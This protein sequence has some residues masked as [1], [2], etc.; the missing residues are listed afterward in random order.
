MHLNSFL[1]IRV[2]P[3]VLLKL[4]KKVLSGTKSL[5]AAS[6]LGNTGRE[7]LIRLQEFVPGTENS[8]DHSSKSGFIRPEF[9]MEDLNNLSSEDR[10]PF[11]TL[12]ADQSYPELD[13]C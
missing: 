11:K 2:K 7:R 9:C 5:T 13:N 1:E 6:K 10:V 8:S 12:N 3:E 4:L